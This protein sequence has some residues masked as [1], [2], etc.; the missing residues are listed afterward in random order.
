MTQIEHL[1]SL[2]KACYMQGN[3]LYVVT[4]TGK[5][6]NCD[7]VKGFVLHQTRHKEIIKS[8]DFVSCD[9]LKNTYGIK[10]GFKRWQE[11]LNGKK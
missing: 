2:G 3:R 7:I 4:G 8:G 9:E 10:E 1:L 11:F 5:N 6:K